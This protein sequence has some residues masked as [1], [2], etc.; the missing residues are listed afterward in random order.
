MT[1][2]LRQFLKRKGVSTKSFPCIICVLALKALFAKESYQ[3]D[4]FFFTALVQANVSVLPNYFHTSG[5]KEMKVA[6]PLFFE[7]HFTLGASRSWEK[8]LPGMK[9]GENSK[10]L[11]FEHKNNDNQYESSFSEEE[12]MEV[13]CAFAFEFTLHLMSYICLIDF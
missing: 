2:Q 10:Q 9:Q 8:N 1:T 6:I 11:N 5:F 4:T 7:N 3:A 12:K 13:V